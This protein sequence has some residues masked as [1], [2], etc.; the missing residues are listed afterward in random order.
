MRRALCVGVDL[1]AFG[2][3]RGCVADAERLA[4]PL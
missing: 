3:L 4:G 2:P 1:Y